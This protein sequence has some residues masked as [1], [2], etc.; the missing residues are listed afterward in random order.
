MSQRLQSIRVS[1]CSRC[2]SFLNDD[3]EDFKHLMLC[4]R[5]ARNNERNRR[6]H[7][8]ESVNN[9]STIEMGPQ[10]TALQNHD[11]QSLISICNESI[12]I[13]VED[14]AVLDSQATLT[15]IIH[16]LSREPTPIENSIICRTCR[17]EVQVSLY[18]VV[19]RECLKCIV[20]Q[21]QNARESLNC[22]RLLTLDDYSGVSIEFCSVGSMTL[23][24]HY[25][26][27]RMFPGEKLK[28]SSDYN[29]LFGLCCKQ[30][31]VDIPLLSDPFPQLQELLLDNHFRKNIRK[32]NNA[33]A[34][35]S[36]GYYDSSIPGGVINFRIQ[37]SF[38]HII[39]PVIPAT[40]DS[41][42]FL[43]VY[44]NDSAYD[45][46]QEALFDVSVVKQLRHSLQSCNPFLRGLRTHMESVDYLS[47]PLSN[48]TIRILSENTPDARRYNRPTSDEVA[49]IM[50]GSEEDDFSHRDVVIALKGG[51]LRRISEL[52]RS[53]DALHY[54]LFHPNGDNGWTTGVKY[55]NDSSKCVTI[56]D[57]YAYR[58]QQRSETNWIFF[59]AKL[60]LQYLCDMFAKMEGNNLNFVRQNQKALRSELYSGLQ[61]RISD[62][63]LNNIGKRI[64]LPSSFV[65]SPRYMMQ[66][67]N[68]SM[69]IVKHC[70]KP[71]LFLTFTANPKWREIE[72]SLPAGVTAAERPDIVS[73]VFR[74]K[75][76]HL[77]EDLTKRH[78]FGKTNGFIYVVEF[79]KR[80]LPHAHILIILESQFKPRSSDDYDKF[81]SAE[82]PDPVSNPQLHEIITNTMIHKCEVGKCLENNVCKKKF[83]KQFVKHSKSSE[84][85]YPIY[86]RRSPEDGGLRTTIAGK[87]YD[88]RHV[89]PYNAFL[90]LKYQSHLNVEICTSI[91]SVKYLYKYVYKGQ[92]R[93]MYKVNPTNNVV[94]DEKLDE[95]SRYADARY[96]SS[97]EAAYRIY[98][99]DLHDRS[100]TVVRLDLHLPNA[101][102]VCFDPNDNLDM[103]SVRKTTLTE[104]FTANRLI[105]AARDL[106]Y[107]EMPSRFRWVGKQWMLRQRHMSKAPIGRM[108]NASPKEGERFFLRLLLSHIRGAQSFED[109]RTIHGEL[110]P[111][112]QK[113]CIELGL[114][115]DDQEWV[116]C[117][118]EAIVSCTPLALRNL[119]VIILVFALPSNP[120]SM[121][122]LFQDH[123]CEDYFYHL[124]NLHPNMHNN[125]RELA[126]TECLISLDY[127]LQN[128]G[129]SLQHYGL[130]I[131]NRQLLNNRNRALLE[132]LDFN[133]EQLQQLT[134]ERIPMLQD[135]QRQV[136]D[137]VNHALTNSLPLF[138][139]VD[140]PGGSGKTFTW[141]T[142]LGFVRSQGH[143][144]LATAAS[145]IASL[146]LP[147]GRTFHSRFKCPLDLTSS[148]VC[149]IPKQSD[150]AKLIQECKVI[151][152]DEAPMAHKHLI[153]ALD[154]TL[155]DIMDNSVIFGGK[156][157]L[158]GG[159]FRQILPVIPK[160]SRAD[161]VKAILKRSKLW[162][163]SVQFK[164]TQNMRVQD[165]G[166]IDFKKWLLDLGEGKLPT[167]EGTNLIRI[168]QEFA[169]ESRTLDEFVNEIFNFDDMRT[170]SAFEFFQNRAI[171]TPLN[172]QVDII[173]NILL[174][175]LEGQE[176][177]YKS[178]DSIAT[179]DN[180]FLYPTEFLNSITF[181]GLPSHLLKLKVGAPVIL[182]R[183]LN[184]SIG[185]ANGTR[186]IVTELLEKSV[187]AIIM[188]GSRQGCEVYIPRI[189]LMP[190]NSPFP[191]TLQRIQFPLKLAFGMTINKS[192]G[193]SLKYVG[194]YLPESV[195]THGQLYVASSRVTSARGLKILVMNGT[196]DG[197]EGIYTSNVVYQEVLQD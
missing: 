62:T 178:I 31:K 195:F 155:R 137:A 106:L 130:P 174:Q 47:Q 27:A 184:P 114:L 133:Q 190:S 98:G 39:G 138:A 35:A 3:D 7:A 121:W 113:A 173:N 96:V 185:L 75:L 109:L 60:F 12:E 6:L 49:V 71:D 112:F 53:Y 29:P 186:L 142:I 145:G 105:P 76:N 41:P 51:G 140:G 87:T 70:G 86:R 37:G 73:R 5:C 77:I 20:F 128:H 88:N 141:E 9:D 122:E 36:A 191:F 40:Q 175:Q 104:Y 8:V 14:S 119:F 46:C 120:L 68:D 21:L 43:Q 11:V 45:E 50:H 167:I 139:F 15:Q 110:Q 80:G 170:E 28:S 38:S 193:Q 42:K 135:T 1:T 52:H 169:A 78:I 107:T 64:V 116:R 24:C 16:Q 69:S 54:V 26:Q 58:L 22:A 79:Q 180:P 179:D 124:N 74:L 161:T 33:L 134:D 131:P 194:V 92:D 162:N 72:E 34:F 188:T 48:Y 163:E 127:E 189:K 65:G 177:C 132:E 166:N 59:G 171:L 103:E 90:S 84:D 197:Y 100:H 144:A 148:S 66:L 143:I 2:S 111:T 94:E 196:L 152:F 63:E 183:N 117:L 126:V 153:E 102:T 123:L 57:F 150:L 18:D 82:I 30:G 83:P 61:D 17:L 56:K 108:Y 165:E 147:S 157:V 81:V 172:S 95:V 118:E 154:R 44:F 89:V 192:Q 13:L 176:K 125:N 181:S 32:Y 101:N 151:I 85:S 187:K 160:G 97:C 158:M 55:N 164:L 99:F 23:V 25:C 4:K 115:E 146:L 182:L 149:N 168:P 19:R 129:L 93:V 136:F 159:D 91:T 67:Y 10:P 156:I